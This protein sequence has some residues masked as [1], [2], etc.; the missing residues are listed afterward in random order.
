[1]N[2]YLNLLDEVL[3][4]GE[5][6]EN[7]TGVYTLSLV[8]PQ[9][10]FSLENK[11]F[12]LVTTKKMFLR[13]IFEE[14]MWMLRGQTNSKVL[15]EKN[16]N[17]WKGNSTKEFLNSLNLPYPEGEL[18]PI[19]GWQWTNFN[20]HYDTILV[21]STEE[22]I[23]NQQLITKSANG[24]D[25]IQQLLDN[26]ENDPFSRRHILT[27]WNPCQIDKMALPPCHV[28]SQ[29]IVSNDN[30]LSCIMYQRSADL[31]LGIPFNIASYALLTKLI[32]HQLGYDT[33]ELIIN[34][35]DA[36]IYSNHLNQV[37]LQ[38]LRKPLD[39]PTLNI[40]CEKDNIEDY[41]YEDI[42]L[43]EYNSYST[44]KGDMVS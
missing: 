14:L 19:Y 35:G 36:H 18:G 7:R 3:K 34:I 16:V 23:N 31:F 28:M 32:A 22:D 29:F 17:I 20:G 1:M 24:I 10:R 13:G 44:I 2:N 9:L 11:S 30:K 26:L 4:K 40:K 12:P 41:E 21:R 43:I 38:I 6:R 25:Q 42:E 33:K 15:E 5:K 37:E 27:A 39:P 8:G